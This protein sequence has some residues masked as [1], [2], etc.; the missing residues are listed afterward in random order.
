MN[1]SGTLIVSGSTENVLRIWDTRTSNKLMKLRGHT[2]NIRSIIMNRDGTQ[3][4]S[5]GSDGTIRLWSLG[6]QRCIATY[7]A[8]DKGVWTMAVDES[9]SKVYS[10]GR[11]CRVIAT[12]LKSGNPSRTVI[13]HE[14]AP[15]LK[16]LLVP[17]DPDR[18]WISTTNSSIRCWNLARLS[19]GF[20]TPSVTGNG[21]LPNSTTNSSIDSPSSTSTKKHS[22]KSQTSV[23]KPLAEPELII[24]GNSS[25]R[26]YVV[27]NDKRF[28]VTRDTDGNVAIYDALKI[29]KVEDLGNV[30]FDAEVKKR[31]R[32]MYVPNWF[33]VDLKMGMLTIHLEEPEC[34][35][36]WVSAREFGFHHTIAGNKSSPSDDADRNAHHDCSSGA[37]N[38]NGNAPDTKINLG[39]LVLQG[40]FEYWHQSY[41]N[42]VDSLDQLKEYYNDD[43]DMNGDVRMTPYGSLSS[44]NHQK[45]PK[46]PVPPSHHIPELAGPINLYFS[47]PP[48]TP[49]I[50]SENTGNGGN[51]RTLLRFRVADERQVN[52]EQLL[53]DSVPGWVNDVVVDRKL[54]MFNKTS[55]FIYPHPCF[56]LKNIRKEHFSAIDM[57]QI[58]KVIEHVYSKICSGQFPAVGVIVDQSTSSVNGNNGTG[59]NNGCSTDGGNYSTSSASSQASSCGSTCNNHN[60][61]HHQGHSKGNNSGQDHG[62]PG[63]G[64]NNNSNNS[65]SNTYG[66]LGR[67]SNTS[68]HSDCHQHQHE[69]QSSNDSTAYPN[70]HTTLNAFNSL[71]SQRLS[72]AEERIELYC[73][74]A[75]LDS[76][77]DLRTVKHFFWK[78]PGDLVLHYKPK[79]T[80]PL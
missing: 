74:D 71:S 64:N 73:Q 3:C 10:G 50:F 16:L 41:T 14:N 24:R 48:H 22:L 66:S 34:F 58:R 6:Q 67:R 44:V 55:F 62:S 63:N 56:E 54:P 68:H 52:E 40:L 17:N 29:C 18:M 53:I 12:D 78:N 33:T 76:N 39:G 7:P 5:A 36:A 45:G 79:Q 51:Q 42:Y 70:S 20:P 1:A 80:P 43:K 15:I 30:D 11:D 35:L 9:F 37:G 65:N 59:M 21:Y 75:L 38:G 69:R 31:F 4:L 57:L 60:H 28:I 8:H 23:T 13:L 47:V 61:C 77:M 19:N 2:D 49:I 27:L 25:I 46:Y 72:L 26:N 32:M